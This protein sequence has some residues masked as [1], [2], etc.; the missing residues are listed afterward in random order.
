[1]GFFKFL[2]NNKEEVVTQPLIKEPRAKGEAIQNEDGIWEQDYE[3]WNGSDWVTEKYLHNGSE[4]VKKPIVLVIP[5]TKGGISLKKSVISLDKSLI[6]LTKKTGFNFEG[7]VAKVA[8]VLDYSGSMDRLYRS[9]A[10]QDVLTRLMPLSLKFDDNGELEV[11]LFHHS[12]K[13]IEPLDLSNFENYVDDVVENSGFTMG[14]TK[15]EPVLQDVLRKYFIEEASTSNIPSFIIFITDGE[16][17]DERDTNKIIQE[18]AN[19]NIFIQFVGIGNE[20]F[21]YLEQLDD[22]EGRKVDNTGFIKVQ[23]M[24]KLNDE[25]LYELL[26]SQYPDWLKNK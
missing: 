20:R 22:L 23:D 15:Y 25:D 10:V 3:T 24:A 9:G 7:H 16:N 11:W 6:S 2:R 8:V 14:A 1:M 12:Y 5:D 4:W 26:L 17:N 19:H 21:R 18:S 13:R